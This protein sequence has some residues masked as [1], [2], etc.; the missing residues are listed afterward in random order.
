MFGPCSRL[1][2]NVGR[3]AACV[4]ASGFNVSIMIMYSA[5]ISWVSTMESSGNILWVP[6]E[7]GEGVGRWEAI[8]ERREASD[9]MRAEMKISGSKYS[10]F[11][12]VQ[13]EITIILVFPIYTI[14]SQ[15]ALKASRSSRD[16]FRNV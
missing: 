8:S 9:F 4:D 16:A 6:T 1:E 15:S 13:K 2:R 5:K 11:R 3:C 7:V 10:F 14:I 12:R